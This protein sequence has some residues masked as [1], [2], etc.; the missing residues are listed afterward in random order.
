MMPGPAKRNLHSATTLI[1]RRQ[2][3]SCTSRGVACCD[4][5]C[6]G[7]WGLHLRTGPKHRPL[8]IECACEQ[9]AHPACSPPGGLGW[10]QGC[11]CRAGRRRELSAPGQRRRVRSSPLL[12]RIRRR[13]RLWRQPRRRQWTCP[14]GRQWRRPVQ[15]QPPRLCKAIQQRDQAG[16]RRRARLPQQGRDCGPRPT[17]RPPC[18]ARARFASDGRGRAQPR[19][20]AAS[21]HPPSPWQR[22]AGGAGK[23]D[24]EV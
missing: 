9:L 6:T 7:Q 3:I 24:K 11:T 18:G 16:I 12:A 21:R 10:V 8:T 1:G 22:R 20:H 14:R 19:R 2:L 15:R 13:R 4:K 23:F 17:L 5:T